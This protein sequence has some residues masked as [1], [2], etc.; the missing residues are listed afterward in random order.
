MDYCV[1]NTQD[2]SLFDFIFDETF[3]MRFRKE[4]P[5]YIFVGIYAIWIGLWFLIGALLI[6]GAVILFLVNNPISGFIGFCI[7]A[8]ILG[9]II[10]K[11]CNYLGGDTGN[12]EDIFN[13]NSQ[14][15]KIIKG[16]LVLGIIMP[17]ALIVLLLSAVF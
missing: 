6:I 7:W 11:I 10:Y 14:A 15:D 4:E 1:D 3:W 9:F 13:D 17:I 5:K 2:I 12:I 16:W 8:T